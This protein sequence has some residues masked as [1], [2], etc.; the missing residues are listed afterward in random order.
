MTFFNFFFFRW[1]KPLKRKTKDENILAVKWLK[2]Q[3]ENTKAHTKK[4]L[5]HICHIKY[6]TGL[7]VTLCCI[8]LRGNC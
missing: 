7:G 5:K 1:I 3:D 8:V 6:S 4:I 2:M